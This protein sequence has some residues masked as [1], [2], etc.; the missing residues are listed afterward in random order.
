[1]QYT[2]D[3]RHQQQNDDHPRGPRHGTLNT[4]SAKLGW[5]VAVL[6]WNWK[7]TTRLWSIAILSD[8]PRD[9]V[10]WHRRRRSMTFLCCAAMRCCTRWTGQL[11]QQS[12]SLAPQSNYVYFVSD[13]RCLME[14]RPR[15]DFTHQYQ[16]CSH[17]LQQNVQLS[18][19][20]HTSISYLHPVCYT[21]CLTGNNAVMAD[22]SQRDVSSQNRRFISQWIG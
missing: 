4:P 10:T 6:D 5:F 14:R 19:R 18:I 13:S 1:V 7:K 16:R 12:H 21:F 3:F 15:F 2:I 11:Q 22:R 17:K 8:V 9:H 20:A